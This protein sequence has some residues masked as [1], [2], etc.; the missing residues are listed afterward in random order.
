MYVYI[1]I[2]V[3]AV[4]AVERRR[5]TTD[6]SPRQPAQAGAAAAPPGLRLRR[7][8]HTG[9]ASGVAV[10]GLRLHLSVTVQTYSV[11]PS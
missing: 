8:A 1:I 4:D 9:R 10:W 2:S 5:E 6:Q 7:S 3:T 11:A